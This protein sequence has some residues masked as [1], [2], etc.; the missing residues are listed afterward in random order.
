MFFFCEGQTSGLFDLAGCNNLCSDILAWISRDQQPRDITSAVKYLI[1]AIGA[2]TDS[3]QIAASY[4]HYAKALALE[5]LDGN[6][7][8]GTVQAFALI[9]LY[10][11][12][13]CQING[14]FLFFG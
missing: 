5:S 3:K 12:R 14:A 4:F 11:L 8:V 13:A 1:L 6:V 7:D 9:A 2:Q 10:M